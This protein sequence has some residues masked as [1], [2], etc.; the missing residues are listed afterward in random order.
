MNPK[1]SQ[2]SET[3]LIVYFGEKIDTQLAEEI[4]AASELIR[5]RFGNMLREVVPSYTSVLIEFHPLKTDAA[6]LTK[7]LRE[8]LANRD[9]E[10]TSSAGKLITLPVYY[11]PETGPDLPLLAKSKGMSVDDVIKIHSSTVYTVCAIGFAPGFAFLAP[12]DARIASP[13]HTTPRVQIPAGSVG[14]ADTQTAVYPTQ[15]PGGW[16]IIGNSPVS[17]FD[18]LREPMMPFQAGDKICFKPINKE[19]FLRAGGQLCLDWK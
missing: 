12:V 14:I 16:Q 1:I 19:T 15:S 7:S 18:P 9:A 17:L 13:R 5:R 4:G 2:V 10:I 3:H 8:T 11:A 6:S